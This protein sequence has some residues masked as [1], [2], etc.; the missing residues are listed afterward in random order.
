MEQTINNMLQDKETLSQQIT[1]LLNEFVDTYDICDIE[2][3]TRD[4]R[5][6][7]QKQCYV[8][9]EVKYY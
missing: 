8:N 2:L 3:V 6:I 9:V 4:E 5:I 1:H 7:G